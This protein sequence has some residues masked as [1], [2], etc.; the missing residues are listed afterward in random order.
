MTLLPQPPFFR[1]LLLSREFI[2]LGASGPSIGQWLPSG[3]NNLSLQNIY[4]CTIVRM[5]NDH[6]NNRKQRHRQRREI[7]KWA[8]PAPWIWQ[9]D[10]PDIQRSSH[11]IYWDVIPTQRF[12]KLCLARNAGTVSEFVVVVK[13]LCNNSPFRL[14]EGSHNSEVSTSI[15]I[16]CGQSRFCQWRQ[17]PRLQ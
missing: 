10:R 17:R 4:T 13:T 3:Q 7:I 9:S 11:G 12:P 5:S 14:C 6:T 8:L 2:Q 1:F 15:A 16:T